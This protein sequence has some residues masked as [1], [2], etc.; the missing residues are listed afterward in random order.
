VKHPIDSGSENSVSRS[1]RYPRTGQQL[2][3]H[4]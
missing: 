2:A 1:D 4:I 3:P